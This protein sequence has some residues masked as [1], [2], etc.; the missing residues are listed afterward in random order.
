MMD[1]K[2]RLSLACLVLVLST[3]GAWAVGEANALVIVYNSADPAS[4]SLAKYYASKRNIPA[5]R[6]LGLNCPQTEEISREEYDSTI[7]G[8]FRD[9]FLQK[10]WWK[11]QGGRIVDSRIRFVVL[12]RG[13][14]L[15]VKSKGLDVIPRRDQPQP[16]ASRDEASVDSELAAL[17]LGE[18]S[19]SGLVPNPFFR[20]F[21]P[22]VDSITDPG[23]L[24][25]CRLDAVS[26][27]TVRAMID[28]AIATEKT[29]L[30]GWGYVDSRSITEGG[31]AEGDQWLGN[32]AS[33]M[34]QKG[35]PV[36]WDKAPEIIP[37]GYPV[38]DAAIYYGWYAD[39]VSGP[40]ADPA[41]Q[42]RTGAVAVHIHSFS[43]S[44]LR[45][46]TANWCGPLLERGAAATLGNV[47]EPYL[48]LTAHLDVFQDRLMAGFTLAESAYM[49][50]RAL[51]WMNVVIGDPLYRPYAAWQQLT[52]SKRPMDDWRRY[53]EIVVAAD[54]SVSS[55]SLQLID[56]ARQTGNSMFLESLAA[57][58]A[59]ASDFPQA[60]SLVNQA[61]E[62]KN[63]PLVRFRLVLEKI[64]LLRATG[65]TSE[66]RTLLSRERSLVPGQAQG[67]LLDTIQLALFPPPPT[68]TP[69]ATPAKK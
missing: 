31:Y 20:R 36:L 11:L 49:S 30:W 25:V 47:Y 10:G 40:F 33:S 32:L 26:D 68:P 57:D 50:M 14:P 52:V 62:M 19:S 44:T 59:D 34:R 29:G 3:I 39:A 18:V 56:A 27:I 2:S 4:T 61:L 55:A 16:I 48:T 60:L 7:A 5:D 8:P 12:M 24:L 64:G 42:F 54:G 21:A 1:W 46:A 23:L 38:T 35:I 17:G 22:I 69:Q 6:L 37:A 41:M 43:A 53:R 58:E 63:K 28:D 67:Q 45:S 65:K 66:I 13:M 51:S 9:A 15:K